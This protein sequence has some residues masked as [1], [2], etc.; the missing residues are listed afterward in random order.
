M[1]TPRSTSCG[2][3][4]KTTNKRNAVVGH[5]AAEAQRCW[6]CAG[7]LR[8]CACQWVSHVACVVAAHVVQTCAADTSLCGVVCTGPGGWLACRQCCGCCSCTSLWICTRDQVKAVGGLVAH[9]LLVA[10]SGEWRVKQGC[11]ACW[12]WA[13]YL[14]LLTQLRAG[15]M[16]ANTPNLSA[17]GIRSTSDAGPLPDVNCVNMYSTPV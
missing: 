15:G 8:T 6:A 16:F 3:S 9:Q 10:A 11:L 1:G 12:P 14:L 17:L 5:A 2:P 4:V 13:S 7:G